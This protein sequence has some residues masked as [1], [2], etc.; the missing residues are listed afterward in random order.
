MLISNVCGERTIG[1]PCNMSS[2]K[3]KQC[4]HDES[5]ACSNFQES[6]SG[7]S[8]CETG[9]VGIQ[10]RNEMGTYRGTCLVQMVKLLAS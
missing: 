4:V 8:N 6:K 7:V 2:R 5:I 9:V 1:D 3:S 10:L